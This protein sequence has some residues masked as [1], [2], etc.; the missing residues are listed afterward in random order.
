MGRARKKPP[1]PV[2]RATRHEDLPRRVD[3]T[4]PRVVQIFDAA[5][6]CFAREGFAN[7]TVAQIAGEAG[8]TK[9]TIHYYFEGKQTLVLELQA[10]VY[11]RLFR[12]IEDALDALGPR[13]SLTS[14]LTAMLRCCR[15][16]RPAQLQVA[17]LGEATRDAEMKARVE[18]A[19]RRMEQLA[20][21][22]LTRTGH[23]AARAPLVV[24]TLFGLTA[25]SLVT[26]D[27]ARITAS[28]AHLASPSASPGS[29]PQIEFQPI[30]EPESEPAPL[31]HANWFIGLAVPA[32]TWFEPFVAAAPPHLRRFHPDDLHLTVAFLGPCGE[33]RAKHAW[34]E[35]EAYRGAPLRA[36]LG[37]LVAMGNPKRP[38]A[39]SLL[40]T[41]G[42]SQAIQLIEELRDPLLQAA[43]ARADK[44]PPK[45]HITLAR[46]ARKAS[47]EHRHEA[48]NWALNQPAVGVEV[49]LDTICLYTWSAD[50]RTQ[51]FRVVASHRLGSS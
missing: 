38:S 44:R 7:T 34:A 40:L 45:P 30:S 25:R 43:S 27:E 13:P 4:H 24:A 14:A 11:T 31:P 51:Q 8:L 21:R 10:F 15:A 3:W 1:A 19:Q 28:L 37:R 23:D 35:A 17:F 22:A 9:S 41:E 33:A 32:G 18:L 12:Q 16:S 46:P 36:T 6:R 20:G 42:R 47:A 29:E 26:D 49:S 48:F 50:R 39:L 2:R 5:A